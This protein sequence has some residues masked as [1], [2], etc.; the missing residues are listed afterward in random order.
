MLDKSTITIPAK[1]IKSSA[2]NLS[3]I[4]NSRQGHLRSRLATLSTRSPQLPLGFAD[5][6]SRFVTS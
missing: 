2:R 1:A 6:H 4:E 3:T 5:S